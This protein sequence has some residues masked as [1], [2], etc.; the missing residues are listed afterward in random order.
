M[1]LLVYIDKEKVTSE[2]ADYLHQ[3]GVNI[4]AYSDIIADLQHLDIPVLVQ[5]DKT[6]YAVYSAIQHP[7]RKESIVEQML[8]IKNET[9]IRGFR[10]AMEKD[11][12]AMVKWM[13]NL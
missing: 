5:P 11:G 6:N 2:V 9:E 8:I 3:E 7:I 13:K 12:V 1:N 4:R 10:H